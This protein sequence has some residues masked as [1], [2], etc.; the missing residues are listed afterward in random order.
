[1]WRSATDAR[2][3][4]YYYNSLT[5]ETSWKLPVGAAASEAAMESSPAARAAARPRSA[6]NGSEGSARISARS[7]TSGQWKKAVDAQSGKPY[8]YAK[9][10]ETRWTLPPGW[11]RASA[12]PSESLPPTA[13]EANGWRRVLD[14]RTGRHYFYHKETRATSWRTPP[15]WVEPSIEADSTGASNDR[16]RSRTT[17]SVSRKG[18]RSLSGES[19]TDEEA[20]DAELRRAVSRTPRVTAPAVA[21]ASG[22]VVGRAGAARSEESV[23]AEPAPPSAPVVLSARAGEASEASEASTWRALLDRRRAASAQEPLGLRHVAA[24]SANT[25][26]EH[27]NTASATPAGKGLTRSDFADTASVTTAGAPAVSASPRMMPSPRVLAARDL[28]STGAIDATGGASVLVAP[29]P[30][31]PGWKRVLDPS[32]GKHYYYRR[33][34]REVRWQPPEADAEADPGGGATAVLSG[35]SATT[36]AASPQA[37]PVSASSALRA[38]M[39]AAHNPV[40]ASVTASAVPDAGGVLHGSSPKQARPKR[41]SVTVASRRS[42]VSSGSQA[43][44]APPASDAIAAAVA[45]AEEQDAALEKAAAA[46]GAAEAAA[47]RAARQAA[48]GSASPA[49]RRRSAEKRKKRG[50][51]DSGGSGGG[52]RLGQATL[53]DAPAPRHRPHNFAISSAAGA[54]FPEV[55][56]IDL[57]L[58]GAH[59]ESQPEGLRH[60]AVDSAPTGDEADG[61]V[62]HTGDE[63]AAEGIVG[64]EGIIAAAAVAPAED[65][66]GEEGMIAAAT[67]SS[68]LGSIT[69]VYA[70]ATPSASPSSS[71]SPSPMPTPTPS[72]RQLPPAAAVADEDAEGGDGHSATVVTGDVDA[73]PAA[74]CQPQIAAAAATRNDHADVTAA[75]LA[76][77][78]LLPAASDRRSNGAP[79]AGVG[80]NATG[81]ASARTAIEHPPL[82]TAGPLGSMYIQQRQFRSRSSGG[83]SESKSDVYSASDSEVPTAGWPPQAAS[84]SGHIRGHGDAA[85]P[86]P[87]TPLAA[88]P[89]ATQRIGLGA[90]ALGSDSLLS[91]L[92]PAA[93]GVPITASAAE[94]R[95]NLPPS[96]V[97]SPSAPAVV[98]PAMPS[99]IKRP[100]LRL[101][102]QQHAV[103]AAAHR[104]AEK[105]RSAARLVAASRAAMG[106]ADDS[107]G[108]SVIYS[109][110]PGKSGDAA[111]AAS[112]TTGY[113]PADL[114]GGALTPVSASLQLS[115]PLWKQSRTG[116]RRGAWQPRFWVT[117]R[118][119]LLYYGRQADPPDAPLGLFDLRSLTDLRLGEEV[120]AHRVGPA[121][122]GSEQDAAEL[123]SAS[124]ASLS[125]RSARSSLGSTS[126]AAAGAQRSSLWRSW[127]GLTASAARDSSATDDHDHHDAE[128]RV[129]LKDLGITA[130]SAVG[131]GG[132]VDTLVDSELG[133]LLEL[134][135]ESPMKTVLLKAH[136]Q[137]GALRWHAGI[138]AICK[139]YGCMA[140]EGSCLRSAVGGESP[141]RPTSASA[142]GV[143][144]SAASAASA[145]YARPFG[146][147]AVFSDGASSSSASAGSSRR[148]SLGSLPGSQGSHQHDVTAAAAALIGS[149]IT[150]PSGSAAAG[151]AGSRSIAE[152]SVAA[153]ADATSTGS[154]GERGRQLPV[155]RQ[156]RRPRHRAGVPFPIAVPLPHGH[157]L[158]REG[159]ASRRRGQFERAAPHAPAATPSWSLAGLLA[160]LRALGLPLAQPTNRD[161]AARS[162]QAS[163]NA[164][165]LPSTR[166]RAHEAS[167]QQLPSAVASSDSSPT[168]PTSDGDVPT[169]TAAPVNEPAAITPVREARGAA[170]ASEGITPP[171]QAATTM[172]DLDDTIPLTGPVGHSADARVAGKSSGR[173]SGRTTARSSQ[174]DVSESS[175][176]IANA[177]R[178]IPSQLP[179]DAPASTVAHAAS[180]AAPGSGPQSLAHLIAARRASHD[181]LPSAHSSRRPSADHGEEMAT[182]SSDIL[183]VSTPAPAIETLPLALTANT[184]GIH[185]GVGLND[186]GLSSLAVSPATPMTSLTSM[187]PTG[188]MPSQSRLISSVMGMSSAQGMTVTQSSEGTEASAALLAAAPGIAFALSAS[189]TSAPSSA[190]PSAPSS[191]RSSPSASANDLSASQALPP[192]PQG[193]SASSSA[194]SS[195][196]LL[197]GEQAKADA[198]E[199]GKRMAALLAER[200]EDAR[201]RV[202]PAAFQFPLRRG[203]GFTSADSSSSLPFEASS[204]NIAVL[205]PD[206]TD[207]GVAAETPVMLQKLPSR[208]VGIAVPQVVGDGAAVANGSDGSA[209][210]AAGHRSPAAAEATTPPAPTSV[211]TVDLAAYLPLLMSASGS[212]VASVMPSPHTPPADTAGSART[213]SGSGRRHAEAMAATDAADASAFPPAQGAL[214]FAPVASVAVL[215]AAEAGNIVAPANTASQAAVRQTE[216]VPPLNLPSDVGPLLRAP[217][218]SPAG[219]FADG[220]AD[221][222][223]RLQ[224]VHVE[225]EPAVAEKCVLPPPEAQPLPAYAPAPKVKPPRLSVDEVETVVD[226]VTLLASLQQA[227]SP[228]AG[229]VAVAASGGQVPSLA[230]AAAAP[231]VLPPTGKGILRLRA[232]LSGRAAAL[233]KR[234]AALMAEHNSRLRAAA[235]SAAPARHSVRTQTVDTIS[236]PPLRED[237]PSQALAARLVL[238]LRAQPEAAALLG[239]SL[240]RSE[241]TARWARL[242][243]VSVAGGPFAPPSIFL[244][245]LAASA[246]QARSLAAAAVSGAASDAASSVGAATSSTGHVRGLP[247]HALTG[248]AGVAASLLHELGAALPLW[249]ALAPCHFA[250]AALLLGPSSSSS[251]SAS[252]SPGRAILAPALGPL[253]MAAAQPAARLV[254]ACSAGADRGSDAA[255]SQR[256]AAVEAVA[257]FVRGVLLSPDTLAVIPW[258]AAAAIYVLYTDAGPAEAAAAL[259][260]GLLPPSFAAACSVAAGGAVSPGSVGD[261]E[262]AAA[263]HATAAATAA[264]DVFAALA[265]PSPPASGI[266]LSADHALMRA[267]L[268]A[269][270]AAV[271]LLGLRVGSA[272]LPL[273]GAASALFHPDDDEWLISQMRDA[274]AAV[275]AAADAEGVS[276]SVKACAYVPLELVSALDVQAQAMAER[277]A[278][279]LAGGTSAAISPP[280]ELAG[281]CIMS[282]EDLAVAARAC[283]GA[284]S[285]EQSDSDLDAASAPGADALKLPPPHAYP[286][287]RPLASALETAGWTTWLPS[288]QG[289]SAATAT[290]RHD[291][292]ACIELPMG[293]D[294]GQISAGLAAG[295][296][297]DTDPAVVEQLLELPLQLPAARLDSL[298][299]SLVR[300]QA[301]AAETGVSST[302]THAA[303][304]GGAGDLAFVPV[305]V[306]AD[307]ASRLQALPP[308]LRSELVRC[309]YE[310]TTSS[311]DMAAALIEEELLADAQVLV[312]AA[313]THLRSQ[314]QGP[315]AANA[316]A[317]C[318]AGAALGRLQALVKAVAGS[319]AGESPGQAASAVL[320]RSQITVEHLGRLTARPDVGSDSGSDSE[321]DS[322]LRD[323]SVA[324][325]PA[326]V[327][328]DAPLLQQPPPPRSASNPLRSVQAAGLPPVSSNS[329]VSLEL[330]GAAAAASGLD[331]SSGRAGIV[332]AVPHAL[333]IQVQAQQ[334]QPAASAAALSSAGIS[335]PAP[336]MSRLGRAVARGRGLPA[337]TQ[338]AVEEGGEIFARTLALLSAAETGQLQLPADAQTARLT[339]RATAAAGAATRATMVPSLPLAAAAASQSLP[340]M[341]EFLHGFDSTR[342]SMPEATHLLGPLTSRTNAGT[343]AAAATA[344]A[345][346]HGAGAASAAAA[347]ERHSTRR[348][349][350]QSGSAN[351]SGSTSAAPGIS[352]APHAVAGLSNVLAALAGGRSP[353][354]AGYM[355][356]AVAGSFSSPQASM[357]AA[358]PPHEAGIPTAVVSL[359]DLAAAFAGDGEGDDN[360]FEA[361]AF[362]SEE[363]VQSWYV[364]AA[365]AQRSQVSRKGQKLSALTTSQSTS[366][367][368]WA[369]LGAFAHPARN[370]GSIAVLSKV[371]QQPAA[372]P[373][374]PMHAKATAVE[375]GASLELPRLQPGSASGAD[376]DGAS[377]SGSGS[378]SARMAIAGLA[379]VH[380]HSSL[381]HSLSPRLAVSV[382]QR[383]SSPRNVLGPRTPFSPMLSSPTLLSYGVRPVLRNGIGTSAAPASVSGAASASSGAE[384]GSNAAL[385]SPPPALPVLSASL[386]S[387]SFPPARVGSNGGA[388][389]LDLSSPA[390]QAGNGDAAAR[391]EKSSLS[392]DNQAAVAAS[393]PDAAAVSAAHVASALIDV[394][395]QVT[396]ARP[397]LS[398]PA[399]EGVGQGQV[400]SE[401]PSIP[402]LAVEAL[403]GRV[404]APAIV[405]AAALSPA[406]RP[407][408]QTVSLLHYAASPARV[409]QL[410]SASA[411]A[412]AAA[413]TSVV[414]SASSRSGTSRQG[415][416]S[417]Q[418]V[419]FAS[420]PQQQ[421]QLRSSSDAVD[422]HSHAAA[423]QQ[424]HSALR[425]VVPGV[426]V[427][428]AP[429]GTIGGSTTVSTAAADIMPFVSVNSEGASISATH[430]SVAPSPSRYASLG[431]LLQS[432]I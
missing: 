198:L 286:W 14:A 193:S 42:S 332:P 411:A 230:A 8:F 167:P 412:A 410:Q 203:S 341:R 400:A 323:N 362:A 227:P 378:L 324:A 309:A 395:P 213:G 284:A 425:Q 282:A 218:P 259:A 388:F 144:L 329:D 153:P 250:P 406:P 115:G 358:H 224:V 139:R 252:I 270:A 38:S 342:P 258:P 381:G 293:L 114:P 53:L 158:S 177:L 291:A 160:G 239:A 196:P 131:D 99:A 295:Q 77:A 110:S 23:L 344:S 276:E 214:L 78:L 98:I 72:P 244:R 147:S 69:P 111:A 428:S 256:S 82:L 1:M 181:D 113:L 180:T 175:R 356:A 140:S 414:G 101:V 380:S 354:Q 277:L 107:S 221:A 421:E 178:G 403:V 413:G 298:R 223:A 173:S 41:V 269:G 83:E 108:G 318:G 306:T 51:S 348:D 405:A 314:E 240:L 163:T 162:R 265:W 157:S 272:L 182:R 84:A 155:R 311:Q 317:Y 312:E 9:V 13:K 199:R 316:Y 262:A 55:R 128:I 87:F 195:L 49:V 236:R 20:G 21:A 37:A 290:D 228:R 137:A 297:D 365:Q 31:P 279:E 45:A 281:R 133:C 305:S 33:D 343:T 431:A 132:R 136:S 372:A 124:A 379:S 73:G 81:S 92:A 135:G 357:G 292:C 271:S 161:E 179:P 29:L 321:S 96:R 191:A 219:P 120:L 205:G 391:A 76:S 283:V 302:P 407:R 367:F 339:D 102:M 188:T 122:A 257:A 267:L 231:L 79:S 44:P 427:S 159:A 24:S 237:H 249:L 418:T 189:R 186:S 238:H 36:H 360:D 60:A 384:S 125:Q 273:D 326:A 121:V 166:G 390:S 320:S 275:T 299:S 200:R 43:E 57:R 217:Q 6:S 216:P 383:S 22:K 156:R 5:K 268:T 94:P 251:P 28:A 100:N 338:A 266:M 352:P 70:S 134:E 315:V 130:A 211:V 149:S 95:L 364:S 263:R 264:V 397:V 387:P 296:S 415:H 127:L 176:V 168:S 225:P 212:A 202:Q 349:S 313:A 152:A 165:R 71:L 404:K 116:L 366:S 174:S 322:K 246:E 396:T 197:H 304:S 164:Q 207:T 359:A 32:S 19:G 242:A 63:R 185:L 394:S 255:L 86:P 126:A 260:K 220:D 50:S 85:V 337:T 422:S 254:S 39:D 64:V 26:A 40:L 368:P 280:R 89:S 25:A 289:P 346:G 347:S 88:L 206:A 253:Q 333:P 370:A 105:A 235:A 363:K 294:G 382:G 75:Y 35:G 46:A 417:G 17:R 310:V 210:A 215:A 233:Q 15:G 419:R 90:Y 142:S 190:Q 192:R 278:S 303:A 241:D 234:C 345:R 331:G 208:A 66:I 209:A 385:T 369:G 54:G 247:V 226:A 146:G 327:T 392:S 222:S 172:R 118:W 119:L 401:G 67:V 423:P 408:P 243:A 307:T 148:S 201:A 143:P 389:A 429:T 27:V 104:A 7:D 350:V 361:A 91:V 301:F 169:G 261:N 68:A 34:T 80:S 151:P 334:D 138:V 426:S 300:L 30:L 377:G 48:R 355:P 402:R 59:A 287:L 420:D 374:E 11:D 232:G 430:R 183:L 61:R 285:L 424:L 2:G 274:C 432:L 145:R 106:F 62:Q 204:V 386:F 398:Q 308:A 123:P 117:H 109:P 170:A 93:G 229:A 154:H 194:S 52:S 74:L 112:A 129:A 335:S 288:V 184:S 393:V 4:T 56:V 351:S 103:E 10:T 353:G 340:P 416:A 97:A 330:L 141:A 187:T 16:P 65:A 245:L 171:A 328:A 47:R 375:E 319:D 399:R 409:P 58:P 336:L 373:A 325:G 376:S 12:V 371:R 3:R 150:E 18:R 248:P